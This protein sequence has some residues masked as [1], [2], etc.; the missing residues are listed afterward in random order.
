M[1]N[2]VILMGRLVYQPEIKVTTGGVQFTNFTLAV[3]RR[4]SKSDEEKQTDFIDCRAW[5]KN[6][7]FICNYFGKG[8]MI[9]VHGEIQTYNYEDKNGNKRKA[10]E[11]VVDHASFTGEKSNLT[12]FQ[13]EQTEAE[14]MPE[15]FETVPGG[16]LDID[17]GDDD[18]VPF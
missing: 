10:V 8:S 9:A 13:P 12:G 16:G 5:N 6:A 11:V 2:N 3:E 4:F 15:I 14:Q 18:D 7:A 17:T 1:I